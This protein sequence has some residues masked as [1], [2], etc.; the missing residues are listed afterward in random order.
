MP[1]DRVFHPAL[2]PRSTGPLPAANNRERKHH[3]SRLILSRRLLEK[4]AANARA[5]VR[6]PLDGERLNVQGS[7]LKPHGVV[8]DEQQR[9]ETDLTALHQN[10]ARNHD[11]LDQKRLQLLQQIAKTPAPRWAPTVVVLRLTVV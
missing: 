9:T 7:F 8:G 1:S 6:R 11:D 3:R 5:E 10:S 2:K 4:D